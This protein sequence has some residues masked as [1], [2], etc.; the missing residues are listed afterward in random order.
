MTLK[1][2]GLYWAFP[3]NAPATLS[4]NGTVVFVV[5]PGFKDSDVA[6]YIPKEDSFLT[7]ENDFI[8]RRDL[9]AIQ[10]ND[11]KSSFLFTRHENRENGTYTFSSL[12]ERTK[13]ICWDEEKQQLVFGSNDPIE[14]IF[15]ND[16]YGKSIHHSYRFGRFII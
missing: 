6:L 16:Y 10:T 14:C 1:V 3:D 8:T 12:K 11:T 7:I 2:N 9:T 13:N 15:E 4:E 5:S